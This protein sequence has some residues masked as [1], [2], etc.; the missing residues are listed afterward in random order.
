MTDNRHR[1]NARK[2]N[3]TPEQYSDLR[4]KARIRLDRRLKQV[5]K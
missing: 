2:L 1:N 4:M 3:L 5:H